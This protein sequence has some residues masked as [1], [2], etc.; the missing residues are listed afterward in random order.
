M[1]RDRIYSGADI[2][3]IIEHEVERTEKLFF[4][5]ARCTARSEGLSLAS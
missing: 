1:M 3:I 2:D 5:C 4:L